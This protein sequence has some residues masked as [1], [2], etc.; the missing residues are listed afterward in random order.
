MLF[1]VFVVRVCVERGVRAEH[2]RRVCGVGAAQTV[3]VELL[4][5]GKY[6]QQAVGVVGSCVRRLRL[7]LLFFL[8]GLCGRRLF[9]IGSRAV[10]LGFSACCVRR[11]R[12]CRRSR[13]RSCSVRKV[14]VLVCYF[15]CHVGK[16]WKR[17]SG[18]VCPASPAVGCTMKCYAFL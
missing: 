10:R 2:G 7:V 12:C 16:V 13:C 1:S 15:L 14:V 8:F 17:G 11:N 4:I 5:S 3:Y 18:V 9:G 6:F